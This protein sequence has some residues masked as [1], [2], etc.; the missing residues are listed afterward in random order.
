MNK[1]SSYIS[2]AILTSSLVFANPINTTVNYNKNNINNLVDSNKDKADANNMLLLY[3]LNNEFNNKE[4][5][6][7]IFLSDLYKKWDKTIYSMNQSNYLK[8]VN[9]IYS[10]TNK[11]NSIEWKLDEHYFDIIYWEHIEKLENNFNILF[12]MMYKSNELN[13]A[14]TYMKYI[15]KHNSYDNSRF[16]KNNFDLDF[17]LSNYWNDNLRKTILEIDNL[18]WIDKKNELINNMSNNSFNLIRYWEDKSKFSKRDLE[19]IDY[20]MTIIQ[21]KLKQL[22]VN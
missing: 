13:K 16:I 8:M 12:S 10:K 21:K 22:Y 1:V 20:L 18:E 9:I 6:L 17:Y 4:K 19:Y 11:I 5:E 15:E 14:V 3:Y 2:W 7:V